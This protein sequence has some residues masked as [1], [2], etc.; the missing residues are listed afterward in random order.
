M[1]VGSGFLPEQQILTSNNNGQVKKGETLLHGCPTHTYTR[2]ITN[3]Q[4]IYT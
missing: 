3:F 4:Q 1:V 2:T